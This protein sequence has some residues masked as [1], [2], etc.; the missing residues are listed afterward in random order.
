MLPESFPAN[1]TVRG[2]GTVTIHLDVAPLPD[3]NW[4][5]ASKVRILQAEDEDGWPVFSDERSL[6]ESIPA[7]PFQQL[8]WG[9][10]LVINNSSMTSIVV[11][12]PGQNPRL[13]PVTLRTDDRSI[14]RLKHLSG[15]VVGEV[16]RTKVPIITIEDL[17]RSTGRTFEGP[18]GLKLSISEYREGS[19]GDV[20]LKI[21]AEMNLFG[22]SSGAVGN[23]SR[24][25]A[26]DQNIGTIQNRL[27]FTDSAGRTRRPQQRSARYTGSNWTQTYEADFRF[28]S[29]PQQTAGAPV[30]V[31]LTGTQFTTIE[32]PFRF[33]NVLLP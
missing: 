23:R 17:A 10:A 33:E 27:Q 16:Y 4:V 21:R 31:V 19:S 18:N 2:A 26:D 22:I 7:Y 6:S 11:A 12:R 3:L 25:T 14:R 28:P 13:A 9:G 8:Q 15:I 29:A 24:F 32:I 5:G 30:K 1:T 20:Y